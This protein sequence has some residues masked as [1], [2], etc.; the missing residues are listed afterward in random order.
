MPIERLVPPPKFHCSICA[1]SPL[2]IPA[3]CNATTI[4]SAHTSNPVYHTNIYHGLEFHFTPSPFADSPNSHQPFSQINTSFFNHPNCAHTPSPSPLTFALT[5]YFTYTR[6]LLRENAYNC[7]HTSLFF[8]ILIILCATLTPFT[9]ITLYRSTSIG[10]PWYTIHTTMVNN[11][12]YPNISFQL[13]RPPQCICTIHVL[14]FSK[15]SMYLMYITIVAIV[16]PTSTVQSLPLT[17]LELNP[18][19]LQMHA[20][21]LNGMHTCKY[22]LTKL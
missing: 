8:S 13:L 17:P 4:T 5:T 18:H 10:L 15:R 19:F 7:C 14:T 11:I 20:P 22:R 3:L 16:Y 2:Q 1:P 21:P 9:Y 12:N 6:H